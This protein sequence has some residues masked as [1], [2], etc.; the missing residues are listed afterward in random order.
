MISQDTS[1]NT[2][3]RVGNRKGTASYLLP[4]GKVAERIA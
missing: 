4:Q 1:R 3:P 2:R